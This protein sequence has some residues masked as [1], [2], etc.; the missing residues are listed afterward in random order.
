MRCLAF[1]VVGL[2]WLP[3]AAQAEE[4]LSPDMVSAIKAATV[5]VKIKTPEIAGSGS[6][7]VVK[8][9][10]DT[11]YVVTNRHVI[12]PKAAEVVIE[13]R[14]AVPA[15]AAVPEGAG[16]PDFPDCR[17]PFPYPVLPASPAA[18]IMPATRIPRGS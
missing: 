6:G 2:A 1:A 11:V 18:T 9:D 12:E 10:E 15:R 7:F 13:R 3:I 17:R 16:C 5:F 4:S 14:S 8:T